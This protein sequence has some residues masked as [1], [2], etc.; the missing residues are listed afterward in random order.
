MLV[1]GS[2]KN[3]AVGD[4]VKAVGKL[5]SYNGGFE[6]GDKDN[7]PNVTKLTESAPSIQS[8]TP[9][10][11]TSTELDSFITNAASKT[12]AP[13]YVEITGKYVVSGSYNNL[14]VDG[15]SNQGSLNISSVLKESLVVGKVYKVTGY[16]TNKS[17]S[18]SPLYAVIYVAKMDVQDFTPVESLTLDYTETTLSLEK[19]ATKTIV[20]TVAPLLADSNLKWTSEHDNIA[21]V[22]DGVI[23]AKEVG[24]TKITCETVGKNS[25]QQTIKKEI[26]VTV[27]APTS[28]TT[29][30]VLDFTSKAADGI[31]AKLPIMNA[32]T[33]SS[34][35]EYNGIT[36]GA[37]KCE[38][39]DIFMFMN[40]KPSV[41][42]NKTALPGDIV[43]ITF[44]TTS[45]AAK[46]SVY[47]LD[48]FEEEN[49]SVLSTSKTTVTGSNQT[50]TLEN[51]DANKRFFNLTAT[52]AA[53]GQIKKI[54]IVY[55]NS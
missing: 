15:T 36:Y 1:Y 5:A 42:Y 26:D 37:N 35:F 48:V 19:N 28:E 33:T 49:S 17:G 41:F 34:S 20:G 24:Q 54:T 55:K 29:T 51:S 31:W 40:G 45:G 25:E 4:Y 52:S 46:G 47:Y 38:Q 8:P 7:T 12:S 22:T 50:A 10:P 3:L 32:G 6:I 21:S 9:T 30:L 18:T 23:L 11:W 39:R 44:E 27:T 43:S 2:V 16:A 14:L 53:N 13:T